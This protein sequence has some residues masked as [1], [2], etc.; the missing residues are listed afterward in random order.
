[1]LA[2][3]QYQQLLAAEPPASPHRLDLLVK[4]AD[5]LVAQDERHAAELIAAAG[6]AAAPPAP[7]APPAPRFRGAGSVL[8]LDVLAAQAARDQEAGDASTSAVLA[9]V[10]QLAPPSLRFLPYREEH[11]RRSLLRIF[12]APPRSTE[13]QHH[14]LAALRE[15]VATICRGGGCSPLPFEAAA[16][17]LEEEE[18]IKGGQVAVGGQEVGGAAALAGG[19]QACAEG[20]IGA[21]RQA[22]TAYAAE[23]FARRMVHQ[24]PANP[25]A[26][27]LLALMLRRRGYAGGRPVTQAHRRQLEALLSGAMRDDAQV[28][29]ASGYKALAELQ[30]ENRGYAGAADT[31]LR[32]L[33]WLQRRRERGHE[34]L[35]HVALALRLVL[36]KALRRLGRLEEAEGHFAAMAGWVTEGE[37]GF[38]EMCGSPPLS[39]H[40]QA[41]RGLA[42][43]AMARGDRAG[44]RA[45]Y[46]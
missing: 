10:C 43:V 24:F 44:A 14:R 37:A 9:E 15:C 40:Q 7:P 25:T 2:A 30:Y 16:W 1:V 22:T 46:E 36:A 35:T 28:D 23:N 45:Q 17:L 42:L 33:R 20:A 19:V 12:S 21:G 41:L 18:E 38:A 27:A 31:A 32:G 34:A 39:I 13:R 29:S 4:L 5:A 6:D 3:R 26:A 11:L 8:E